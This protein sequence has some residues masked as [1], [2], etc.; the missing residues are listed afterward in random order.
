MSIFFVAIFFD[1]FF[2]FFFTKVGW[3]ISDR[4]SLSLS[5]LCDEMSL[6]L[7]LFAACQL[8]Q[9]AKKG[10]FFIA[11]AAAWMIVIDWKTARHRTTDS[12]VL[13]SIVFVVVVAV[14]FL[15]LLFILTVSP[16]KSV[17][18]TCVSVY[19]YA[20]FACIH[21]NQYM[22]VYAM[23]SHNVGWFLGEYE[24][25]SIEEKLL[26]AAWNQKQKKKYTKIFD[27]WLT[28]CFGK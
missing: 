19:K 15:F 8:P 26:I 22:Y 12:T 18:Y 5:P 16:K 3:N 11:V 17:F 24:K 7:L 1:I 9:A 27:C 10:N 25:K 21:L 4:V 23:K 28:F 20:Q 14:G 13:F 6:L 2:A